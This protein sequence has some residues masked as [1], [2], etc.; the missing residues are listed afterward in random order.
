MVLTGKNIKYIIILAIA[1]V[2]IYYLFFKKKPI[3]DEKISADK[4]VE[5]SAPT[6]PTK[7]TEDT[8]PI[9]NEEE[10]HTDPVIDPASDINLETGY[11]GP[12]DC[13][14]N[15]D[16]PYDRRVVDCYKKTD[17]QSCLDKAKITKQ[18]CVSKCDQAMPRYMNVE[19]IVNTPLQ[20]SNYCLQNL[21]TKGYV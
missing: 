2:V 12:Q 3:V 16:Y 20:E 6:E 15:C 17:Y 21:L 9:G 14:E 5:G 1:G 4:K 7:P 8:K 19:Q 13:A 18:L 10:K 11:I